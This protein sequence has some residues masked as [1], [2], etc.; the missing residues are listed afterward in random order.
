MSDKVNENELEKLRNRLSEIDTEIVALLSE[1]LEISERIGAYKRREQ[2]GI[3]DAERERAVLDSAE[4]NAPDRFNANIRSIYSRI[5]EESKTV[6]RQGQNVYLIGMP[7]SGKTRMGKRL[8]K[9]LNMP[10]IDTDKY[11]MQ[12]MSMSIDEIF[13]AL[14]EEAF[15]SMETMVLREIVLKGGMIVAAGGGMPLWG[16]N[17]KLLKN[18][19]VTV[20]LDRKLESLLDQSVRNRPLLAGNVNENVRKLYEKRHDRYAAIADI[21]ID[22]DE[23]GAAERIAREV[24]ELLKTR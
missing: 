11:V 23:K 21:I 5:I 16:D 22:P 1:R 12:R 20:F 19:G 4:N 6:Q 17:A 8:L 18:S 10:L 2:L 24:E 3:T 15:R 13:A 7:D 9:L 14:G